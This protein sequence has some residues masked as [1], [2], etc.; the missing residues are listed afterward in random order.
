MADPVTAVP[1]E[2]RPEEP[3]EQ[4][5]EGALRLLRRRPGFRRAYAAVVTSELGD[6]FQYVALMWSALVAGGPLGVLVVRLADS[7]PALLFGFHGGVLADRIDRR[8]LM[9]GADLVRAA[10]LVPVSAAALTGHLPLW[11]L[12]LAAFLLTA[13]TS[14]FDPAYGALLPAL[15]D[16]RNVQQANALVRSTADAVMVLG[17]AAAGAL[18]AVLPLGAFYAVNAGSFLVSAALLLGVPQ[19]ARRSAAHGESPRVR[20]GFAALR[21]LPSLAFAV[22]VFGVCVTVSSGTWIVG[23]PEFV[24][25]ALDRGAGSFSLVAASYA[26]GSVLAGAILARRQVHRKALVSLLAWTLYLP[27]YGLFALGHSL[28]TAIAGAVCCGLGQGSAW[29]LVNSA[30]QE[31]VPD[32]VLG[33]VM[34][35][36]SLVHRGAH[37][38]GLLFVSPLFAIVAARSVFAASAVTLTLLGAASTVVML[39]LSRRHAT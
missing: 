19:A 28:G 29:V 23:V 18:L 32:R 6:A 21:P 25:H 38:T 22:A 37:A 4:H 12:V 2:L 1:E 39:T 7:V 8:R 17:W 13:A 33:R 9:I 24:R 35:L 3:P 11:G 20:E 36:I 31:Q 27:G 15:V 5:P 34:G 14:Y 10:V 26:A 30:A 16:R